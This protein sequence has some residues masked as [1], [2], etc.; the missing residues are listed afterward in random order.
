MSP[1]DT[2]GTIVVLVVAGEATKVV[3]I[4]SPGAVVVARALGG[5]PQR[6]EAKTAVVTN[7]ATIVKEKVT[8]LVVKG[9][10]LAG[11]CR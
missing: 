5:P 9:E 10:F 2:M 8:L 6:A 1:L 4:G 7:R 11:L 3:G